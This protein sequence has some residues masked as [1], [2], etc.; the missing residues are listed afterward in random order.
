MNDAEVR[1]I[2]DDYTFKSNAIERAV[3][4]ENTYH[5]NNSEGRLDLE[6]GRFHNAVPKGE[7]YT[8]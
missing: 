1:D 5:A 8:E 4:R 3:S 2:Y 7:F 6:A